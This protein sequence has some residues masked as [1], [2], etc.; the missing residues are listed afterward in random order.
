MAVLRHMLLAAADS[1][2]LRR[3]A[4]SSPLARAVVARYARRRFR[5][6]RSK[7]DGRPASPAALREAFYRQSRALRKRSLVMSIVRPSA[8]EGRF[9]PEFNRSASPDKQYLGLW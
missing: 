1:Q 3:L 4:S 6:R 8:G 9:V 5:S 7:S 2:R